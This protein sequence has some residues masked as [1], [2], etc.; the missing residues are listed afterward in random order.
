MI[1]ILNQLEEELATNHEFIIA[2]QKT[3]N[4]GSCSYLGLEND[5]C[6]KGGVIRT[7]KQRRTQFSASRV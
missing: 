2:E 1:D 6:L 7:V 4:F 3:I 5:K